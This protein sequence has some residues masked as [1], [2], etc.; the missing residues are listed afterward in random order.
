M[1]DTAAILT[2]FSPIVNNVPTRD[3][4]AVETKDVLWLRFVYNKTVKFPVLIVIS[5]Y[6]K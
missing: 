2:I 6:K 1:C 3:L 5:H 4:L